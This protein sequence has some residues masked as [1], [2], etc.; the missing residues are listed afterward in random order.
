MGNEEGLCISKENEM[1]WD[2]D[3]QIAFH[4][5]TES[6]KLTSKLYFSLTAIYVYMINTGIAL[7]F[8]AGF[9]G[10]MLALLQRRVGIMVFSE[11]VSTYE[12]DHLHCL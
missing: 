6:L 12:N 1:K 7:L 5:C 11:D 3:T 8:A 9:F 2:L 4:C 10:Y